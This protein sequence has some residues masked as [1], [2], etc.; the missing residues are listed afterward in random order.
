VAEHSEAGW[1]LGQ[2]VAQVSPQLHY[3]GIAFAK[4]ASF[5]MISP[6][7][8]PTAATLPLRGRDCNP[9]T[10]LSSICTSDNVE[11]LKITVPRYEEN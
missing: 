2:R 11:T 1:G 10:K 9:L 7:R 3:R 4:V 8:P 5:A 6:T